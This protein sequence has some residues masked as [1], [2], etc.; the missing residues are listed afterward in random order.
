MKRYFFLISTL[1]FLTGCGSNASADFKAAGCSEVDGLRFDIAG[2]Q[3]ALA[4]ENGDPDAVRASSEARRLWFLMN[5]NSP[6]ETYEQLQDRLKSI[7]PIEKG[8][9]A[10]CKN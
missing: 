6:A 2:Q 5:Y 3:F 1:L 9:K 4:A 8:I 7:G 10:Y